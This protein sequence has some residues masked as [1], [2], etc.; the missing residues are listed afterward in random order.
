MRSLQLKLTAAAAAV[1]LLVGCA[2]H[3]H[4]ELGTSGA[5]LPGTQGCFLR[6]DF[7]GD[8]QVLNNSN[9][10]V[11]APPLSTRNAFLV[12]LAQPVV[13]LNFN[14]RL[15]FESATTSPRICG[16]L[17]AFLLV[18][19]N[20]PPRIAITAVQEVTRAERDR[21]LAE[22]GQPPRRH[23]ASSSLAQPD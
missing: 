10:I 14:L 13:G 17:N 3:P 4:T 15:G 21:L 19:G 23:V 18:P 22:A 12:R 8:W 16:N 6:R 20:T 7:S 5:S 9:L 11:Y 2:A 1:M